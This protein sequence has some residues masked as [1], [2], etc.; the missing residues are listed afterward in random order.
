M[1]TAQLAI[2]GGTPVFQGASANSFAPEWPPSFPEIEEKLLE[3]YRS[4]QWGG[5]KK[6]EQQLMVDYA[7]W[8]G[9]KYSVFMANGTV[10]LECALLAL[11]VGPGDEVIVP[12]VSWMATAQAPLYVGAKTVMVDIDPDT[13][14]IDPARIEEAITSRTKAIIPVHLFSSV[15]DMDKI[16]A[17]AK[18]HGLFIVEDCAHAHG[19]RQHGVGVGSLGDIGSFSFQSSKLMTAGEGG[20]C[21][22]NDEKYA[23]YLFRA[24]HIGGSRL[25]P[26]VKPPM[27]LM[28]HQYRLTDFQAAIILGQLAHQDEMKQKRLTQFHRLEK[29]LSKT[30]GIMLQKSTFQ[31][32]ERAFYFA[33]FLLKPEQ[34]KADADRATIQKALEAEGVFLNIGWGYPIYDMP[35]WN[36]SPETYEKKETPVCEDT[37]YRRQLVCTGNILLADNDVIDK[38]AEAIDK[39]MRYYSAH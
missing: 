25:F 38:F 6:F 29:L 37:I 19:A 16:K 9:A 3:V 14:C 27:G 22:T 33:C 34:L 31:D 30:P 1:T 23:D 18:K 5:C 28:C 10:T 24:S 8:Q 13:M 39:V 15:A 32:D 12:G 36:I 11:G 20:C 21:T 26:G 4:H 35:M 17:I 7:A 2:N